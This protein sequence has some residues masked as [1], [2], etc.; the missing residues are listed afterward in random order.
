MVVE[1]VFEI[2]GLGA[3]LLSQVISS[4]SGPGYGERAL[5]NKP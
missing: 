3:N 4:D 1:A 2:V 5:L